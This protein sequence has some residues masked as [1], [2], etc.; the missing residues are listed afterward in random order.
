MRLFVAIPVAEP[1]RS[2]VLGLLERL[3]Q[4]GWPVRWVG[5]E[6]LHVTLKFF[7]EVA[8]DRLEVIAEAI[9]IA[10]QGTG[11]LPLRLDELGA[12]PSRQRPRIL[13]VGVEA[14]AA[15]ELLQDRIER[16]GEA[17]GF[18]PEGKPFH[19]HLTL[20]RLREGQKYPSRALDDVDGWYEQLSFTG[21]QV[22]LYE[23][24]LTP[25]GPRYEPQLT[26]DLGKP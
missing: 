11:Q 22:I 3:R 17:L 21:D 15:L 13:Y 19:P 18:P 16:G 1:A 5:N 26:L 7:G 24:I 25:H 2:E 14:P 12:F 10:G 4:T 9:R 8:P 20:G 6:G 23:S